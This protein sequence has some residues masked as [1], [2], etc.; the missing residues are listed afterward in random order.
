MKNWIFGIGIAVCL[1]V[2]SLAVYHRIAN[3]RQAPEI[4]I[5]GTIVYQDGMQE[6]LLEGVT[7]KDE[8]D[9]D[10]TASVVVETVTPNVKSETAVVIYAARDNSNN[11]AKASRVVEYVPSEAS[12]SEETESKTAEEKMEKK[13]TETE[14]SNRTEIGLGAGLGSTVG[15]DSA[16]Q[17]EEED[18]EKG[19]ISSE[20]REE[21]SESELESESEELEPGCPVLKLTQLSAAIKVGETFNPLIYVASIEDDYDNI[22]ELWQDIQ[23]SGEYDAYK[24][25]KYELTFYVVDSAGNM[26]NQAK[27]VL[28]V[29]EE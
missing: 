26:S 1:G 14:K 28:K 19:E 27:F 15:K 25:G 18:T 13:E 22:Y 5:D 20:E 4:F 21:E 2:G 17:E 7:A 23:I 9:G 24:A 16:E 11:I 6:E 12:V 29:E 10:V 3:D 8:Q